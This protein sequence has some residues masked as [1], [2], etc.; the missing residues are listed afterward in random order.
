MRQKGQVKPRENHTITLRRSRKEARSTIGPRTDGSAKSGALSPTV[1]LSNVWS[2]DALVA[3][4][5][6]LADVAHSIGGKS[7]T[8]DK[9]LFLLDFF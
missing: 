9:Y 4:G 5:L 3:M 8:N 1:G 2:T 6:S 7:Y